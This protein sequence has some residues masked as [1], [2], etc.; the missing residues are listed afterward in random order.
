MTNN[1]TNIDALISKRHRCTKAES[2]ILFFHSWNASGKIE[3]QGYIYYLKKDGTGM[4]QLFEWWMGYKGDTM[5]FTKAFLERCTFYDTDIEMN[6]AY[7]KA[8]REG[9]AG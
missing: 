1:I 7:A 9:R 3:Y 6:A 4:A 8:K 2:P 5:A